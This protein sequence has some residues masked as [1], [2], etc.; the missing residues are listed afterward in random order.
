M[1]S[2]KIEM[3]KEELIGICA[4]AAFFWSI[5]LSYKVRELFKKITEL[6]NELRGFKIRQEYENKK[7]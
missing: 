4:F 1:Q 5:F 6:E 7:L 2:N 3:T